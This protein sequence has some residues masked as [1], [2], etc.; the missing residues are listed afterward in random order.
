M[1]I[2]YFI[3][4]C[5]VVFI[6]LMFS[7]FF[8]FKD[9]TTIE[10]D[11]MN[12]ARI[13]PTLTEIKPGG[14]QQF[15]V[16]K[17]PARLTAAYATNKVTWFVNGIAGGNDTVG[18][19]TKDGLYRAPQIVPKSP[20]IQIGVDVKTSS[21]QYL[22]ATVLLNSERPKYRTVHEWGEPIDELK[23][24]NDP[25]AITLEENGNI[26]IADGKIKRF[27]NDGA[28][29]N[30][31]G[32]PKGDYKGS[33]AG[34]L[35][36][37]VDHK[38]LIFVSDIKT[39][40]PRIQAIS[41]DGTYLYGFAPK[42]TGEGK[43]MDTKGLAFDSSQHL[44]VGDIDNIRIS[45]FEHSG[46]FLKNIGKKGIFAGEFNVPYGLAFDAND[47]LFVV[48]YFGPCQK[49]TSEGHFLIDFSYPDPPDGPVHF[50]DIA[51]DRWGN[52]YLIVKGKQISNEEFETL[53]DASGKYVHIK[54]YSNNG[55]F[56]T[57]IHLSSKDRQ[58]IRLVVDDSDRIYVLFK[59]ENKIGVE[60][61]AE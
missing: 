35:N 4:K 33:L 18:I 12:R 21:N 19:I 9:G 1:K 6:W 50:I 41:K 61:L 15:Y 56:V 49:M 3:D 58:P 45:V 23:H 10:P 46:K 52:V 22:W 39:G 25:K 20:E 27:T 7:I 42:G 48:S 5:I 57:N 60:V 53:E 11:A 13:K 40:P 55:D 51:I 37:A 2:R 29:I 32:E 16:V 26:L 30:A 8:I 36:I 28:F 47:D 24:F 44:Y 14:E 59:G 38:G 34:P 43:V 17:E 31:I 54:K